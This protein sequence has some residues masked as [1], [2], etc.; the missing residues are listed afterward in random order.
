[1][2]KIECTS[3]GR[4]TRFPS[5][6]YGSAEEAAR[7]VGWRIGEQAGSAVRYCPECVGVDEDYWD[8]MVLQ[9]AYQAGLDR[10]VSQ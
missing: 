4:A 1:M 7:F 3:C 5:S 10:G 9:I 6:T 8:R 2:T